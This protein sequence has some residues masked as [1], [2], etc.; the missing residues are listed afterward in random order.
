[1]G[2]LLPA[3][4]PVTGQAFVGAFRPLSQR[5]G[6]WFIAWAIAIGF[7]F[8]GQVVSVALLMPGIIGTKIAKAM[9][10]ATT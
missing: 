5:V 9:T 4:L 2:A 10:S 1:M 3:A 7:F 8:G 6:R